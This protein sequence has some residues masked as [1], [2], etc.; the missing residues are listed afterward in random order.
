MQIILSSQQ[1]RILFFF[2]FLDHFGSDRQ[3]E[4]EKA[5]KRGM[6]VLYWWDF[7]LCVNFPQVFTVFDLILLTLSVI[8]KVFLTLFLCLIFTSHVKHHSSFLFV[9]LFSYLYESLKLL[10]PILRGTLGQERAPFLILFE[11]KEWEHYKIVQSLLSLPHTCF[12]H[13]LEQLLND[14]NVLQTFPASEIYTVQ[15][16][17][18][19]LT[20]LIPSFMATLFTVNFITDMSTP[21]DDTYATHIMARYTFRVIISLCHNGNPLNSKTLHHHYIWQQL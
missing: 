14:F 10:L 15:L 1:S 20:Y 12:S 3:S 2:F 7:A 5:E 19:V 8:N 16:L 18:R 4:E 11:V 13:L 9:S 21:K 17:S 6:V